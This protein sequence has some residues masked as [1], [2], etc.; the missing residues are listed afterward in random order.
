MQK[1]LELLGLFFR[2]IYCGTEQN[3]IHV[4]SIACDR[5]EQVWANSGSMTPIDGPTIGSSPDLVLNALQDATKAYYIR[6]VKPWL[7]N[8]PCKIWKIKNIQIVETSEVRASLA[9]IKKISESAL[10]LKVNNFF[11]RHPFENSVDTSEFA[12][13][14]IVTE[15]GL[16]EYTGVEFIPLDCSQVKLQ[17]YYDD[18]INSCENKSVLESRGLAANYMTYAVPANFQL[19]MIEGTILRK[20]FL[21]EFPVVMGSSPCADICVNQEDV[22]GQHVTLQWDPINQCIFLMDSSKHG[23]YINSEHRLRDGSRFHLT[24]EGHFRLTKHKDS[25]HFLYWNDVKSDEDLILLAKS[26]IDSAKLSIVSTI[27]MRKSNYPYHQP[28]SKVR[29][30][31]SVAERKVAGDHRSSRRKNEWHQQ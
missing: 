23:T 20:I 22:S 5:V 28:F 8:A 9:E 4:M 2:K 16:G 7:Q 18:E 14:K 17:I 10:T 27:R 11:S 6:T 1:L 21:E 12:G 15:G 25:V 29:A 30:A 19:G 26:A 13:L 3:T 24:G 31:V